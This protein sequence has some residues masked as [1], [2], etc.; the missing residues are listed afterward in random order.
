MKYIVTDRTGAEE[1][2]LF[3][4]WWDHADTARKFN[5]NTESVVS[6]GHVRM[7]DRGALQ[8]G[9]GS[10]SLEINARP[11]TDLDLILRQLRFLT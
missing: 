8:C 10:V 6:A 3:P 9:G 2:I 1:A 5:I 11:E 7:T 4:C